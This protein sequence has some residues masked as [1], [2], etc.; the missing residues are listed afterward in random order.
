[1]DDFR[2]VEPERYM[3]INCLYNSGLTFSWTESKNSIL[4]RYKRRKASTICFKIDLPCLSFVTFLIT[5]LFSWKENS[6][7]VLSSSSP[8]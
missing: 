5:R 6:P 7:D 2:L 8:W 4:S 3:A 1:M